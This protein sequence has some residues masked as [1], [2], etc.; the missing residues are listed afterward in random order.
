MNTCCVIDLSKKKTCSCQH[1]GRVH[2]KG[3][4]FFFYLN[5]IN[6]D[7]NLKDDVFLL[8]QGIYY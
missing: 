3:V 2:M 1:I 5:R 8:G 7:V 6:I 4:R